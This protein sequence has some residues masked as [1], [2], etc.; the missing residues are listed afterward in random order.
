MPIETIE[1]Q[2]EL[3][4]LFQTKGF[5][6][7]FAFPFANHVLKGTGV[8]VGCNR[9]E[10]CLPDSP[11]RTVFPVDPIINPFSALCFPKNYSNLDFVFSSHCLEHTDNWVSVLDYWHTRLK[12]GGVVFLYLPDH[13]QKYWRPYNNRKHNHAFTPAIVSAYF[14]DQPDKW[15]NTFVS[16]VDLNNSFMLISEKK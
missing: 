16:E 9:I 7:E 6:A 2:N 14:T 8:D 10:W 1:F 12:P 13:S 5:A 3:Y 11:N 4:P 15:T